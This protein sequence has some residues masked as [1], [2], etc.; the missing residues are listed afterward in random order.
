MH[1]CSSRW[2]SSSEVRAMQIQGPYTDLFQCHKYI[3]YIVV[4]ISTKFYY[5]VEKRV[6]VMRSDQFVCRP[7]ST[8][9]NVC[10][11]GVLCR[12][13]VG[14]LVCTWHLLSR[15]FLHLKREVLWRRR[16]TPLQGGPHGEKSGCPAANLCFF[17]VAT[18]LVFTCMTRR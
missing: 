5:I 7:C 3:N 13:L 15:Y 12:S 9:D 1:A 18:N 17:F 14:C 11:P 8:P 4:F 10:G 2:R 6:P 16:L